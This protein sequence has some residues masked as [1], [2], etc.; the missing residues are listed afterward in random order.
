VWTRE[1]PETLRTDRRSRWVRESGPLSTGHRAL[2][3]S[4]PGRRRRRPGAAPPQVRGTR[5]G[6]TATET[7]ARRCGLL[8]GRAAPCPSSRILSTRC[9]A[10]H[11]PKT[12][13]QWHAPAVRNSP[14]I[15]PLSAC[16]RQNTP[17]V[18]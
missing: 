14:T 5:P 18:L 16:R 9:W 2:L 17:V 10:G 15:F 11:S 4:H 3:V 7:T 12:A 13:G 1:E 6:V 8:G